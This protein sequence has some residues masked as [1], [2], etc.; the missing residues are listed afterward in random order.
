MRPELEEAMRRQKV[1]AT[2]ALLAGAEAILAASIQDA[3]IEEGTL[4]GS[5]H[6]EPGQVPSGQEGVPASGEAEVRE[7]PS[8]KGVVLSVDVV[9]STPYAAYQHEGISRFTGKPLQYTDPT[10]KPKY[11]QR[12]VLAYVPRLNRAIARASKLALEGKLPTVEL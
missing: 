3:P 7:R 11:L 2:R 9:F 6:L 10:A 4:R 1:G 12:N 5:G 8:A